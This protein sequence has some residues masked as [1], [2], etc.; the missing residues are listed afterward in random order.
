VKR[1]VGELCEIAVGESGGFQKLTTNK[2]FQSEE[3][4]G[5]IAPRNRPKKDDF[6]THRTCRC[7][8][9]FYTCRRGDFWVA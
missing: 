5:S 8:P 1:A 7:V 2:T 3:K 9:D 4:S 6:V